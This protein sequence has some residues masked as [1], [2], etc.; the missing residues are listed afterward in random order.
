M[1]GTEWRHWLRGGGTPRPH[2]AVLG[3]FALCLLLA[4]SPALPAAGPGWGETH[5]KGINHVVLIWLKD[6]GN[7]GHRARI[8]AGS[9]QLRAIPGVLE[10]RV[11][12]VVP[13][14]RAVVDDSF[15]VALVMTFTDT[16]AL[17]AYVDHPRHQ[18]LLAEVFRPLVDRI[19][20]YD[21]TTE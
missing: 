15:D 12:R 5:H 3:L 9:R 21:F 7:A 20:V 6:P 1:T 2:P 4:S 14:D 13:S 17:A 19:L 10:V 18:R 16:A 11:G 8:I